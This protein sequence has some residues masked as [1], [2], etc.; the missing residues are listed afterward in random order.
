MTKMDEFSLPWVDDCLNKL[1][2]MKYFS[3]LDLAGG[4][5]QVAMSPESKKKTT[6]ITHEGL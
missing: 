3:I 6:F 1:F 2:G 4:Y 5:W